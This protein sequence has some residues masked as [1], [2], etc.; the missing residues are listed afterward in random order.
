MDVIEE[1]DVPHAQQLV[2]LLSALREEPYKFYQDI[3]KDKMTSLADA[4]RL[5]EETYCYASTMILST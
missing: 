5:L 1:L 4:F 2:L 3:I